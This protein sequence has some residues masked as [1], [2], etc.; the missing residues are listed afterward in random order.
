M[1]LGRSAE[2]SGGDYF[3][4]FYGHRYGPASDLERKSNL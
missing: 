3:L 2:V 4:L 1:L